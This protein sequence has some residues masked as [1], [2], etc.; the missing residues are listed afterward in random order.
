MDMG[1][2]S[3][4][5]QAARQFCEETDGFFCDISKDYKG[6]K[7]P[8]NLKC[9]FANVYYRAFVVRFAY[10]AHG[11][12]NLVN[13][14]LSCAICFD[15]DEEAIEIPLPLMTDYCDIDVTT[16]LVIPFITNAEGME[17]AF[18][19]LG[20]EVKDLLPILEEVSYNQEMASRVLTAYGAELGTFFKED[21]KVIP[22]NLAHDW[23]ILR[24]TAAPF[25]NYL[26]GNRAKAVKQLKKLKNKTG[27]EER[28]LTLW[29]AEDMELQGLDRVTVN[30]RMYNDTGDPRELGAM[31]VSWLLL[32]PVLLVPYLG[33]YYLCV[34]FEGNRSVYLMGP[35]YNSY[36]CFLCAFLTAIGLSYFTRLKFYKLLYKKRYQQ[37]QELD[38]I[39]ESPGINRFM[40]GF[41]MLLIAVSVAG[42][43]LFTKWNLNFQGNGFVDNTAFWSMDGEYYDYDEVERVYYK[44]DRVN[45]FGD[46][47]DFPSYVLVLKNGK[48]I[49]FYE[50]GEISDYEPELLEFLR[51]KGVKIED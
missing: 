10:T 26:K 24:F 19:S 40:K 23:F 18:D 28:M 36:F 50:Y 3:R 14:I 11:P 44:P 6:D 39:Q 29:S 8:E 38:S 15:K 41:L 2:I 43:V 47:L 16:P 32:T 51:N 37:Y 46:T 13:S 45:D 30:A 22:N 20:T 4:F 42:C 12:M 31:L 9:C 49:D 33:L 5:E 17:Q 21:P 25:I 1:I 27:Y 35:D 48:E 34:W 7:K